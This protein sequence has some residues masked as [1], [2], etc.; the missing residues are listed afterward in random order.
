M[1]YIGCG[2]YTGL[3]KVGYSGNVEQRIKALAIT[4]FSSFKGD[5]KLEAKIHRHLR[6]KF[7][8]K[9]EWYEASPQSVESEI[10]KMFK[11]EKAL[12][13]ALEHKIE[14]HNKLINLLSIL[15]KGK[16]DNFTMNIAQVKNIIYE[17]KT[18][19]SNSDIYNSDL[20]DG[21]IKKH[22][23]SFLN[24]IDLFVIDDD[25]MNKTLHWFALNL[26]TI[27]KYLSERSISSKKRN[28]YYNILDCK[29]YKNEQCISKWLND[30]IP[31]PEDYWHL[32]N[33][34]TYYNANIEFIKVSSLLYKKDKISNFNTHIK[35]F[36]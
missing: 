27:R 25:E 34:I 13:Q 28:F 15:A 2:K 6:K 16:I 23:F 21:L 18:I 22:L 11:I 29:L 1:I 9:G 20:Y 10:R 3:T 5:F 19:I 26:F 24:N 12:E 32:S 31:S 36:T 14:T 8:H 7:K 4:L 17:N 33:K 30:N 35:Q